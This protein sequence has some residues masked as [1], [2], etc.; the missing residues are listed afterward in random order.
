MTDTVVPP[1][2]AILITTIVQQNENVLQIKQQLHQYKIALAECKK[3]KEDV[4]NKVITKVLI[5]TIGNTFIQINPNERYKKMIDELEKQY[6]NSIK[7]I[8]EQLRTREEAL[9][10]SL[11]KLSIGIKEHLK[12]LGLEVPEDGHTESK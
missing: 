6:D 8:E 1:G 5:P 4:K 9:N 7:G 3:I 10:E 11:I 12:G 2:W